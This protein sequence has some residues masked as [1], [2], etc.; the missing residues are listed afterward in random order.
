MKYFKVS[1][2]HEDRDLEPE[3][4]HRKLSPLDEKLQERFQGVVIHGSQVSYDEMMIPWA[5]RSQHVT[6][7]KGKPDPNGFKLWTL[8]EQGYCFDW[9]Y[10]SGNPRM[11]AFTFHFKANFL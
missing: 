5:G 11:L 4:W 9:L 10:Y 1:S 8:A 6:I 3:D 2:V 7:V